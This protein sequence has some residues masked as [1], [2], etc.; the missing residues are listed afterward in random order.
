[1]KEAR[2]ALSMV[3]MIV[4][5]ILLCWSVQ[6]ERNKVNE[7]MAINNRQMEENNKLRQEINNLLAENLKLSN[8]LL[9]AYKSNPF[10]P[11][12]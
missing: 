8:D 12:K 1:M 5:I 6:F 2:L 10:H 7:E 11:F 9:K 3:M 4:A